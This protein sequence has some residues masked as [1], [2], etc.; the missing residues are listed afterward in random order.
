MSF[1]KCALFVALAF[2]INI[3]AIAVSACPYCD[4]SPS[5]GSSPVGGVRTCPVDIIQL[6]VCSPLLTG[7][8]GTPAQT[9][10]CALLGVVGL[11]LDICLRTA[12]DAKVF[13]V[14]DLHIPK[15]DIIAKIATVCGRTLPPNFT[16][17]P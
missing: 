14:I 1:S 7:L 11:E 8:L 12:I 2:L 13:G 3:V 17:P 4:K 9:D 16:C 10:C 6:H 15:L 5:H